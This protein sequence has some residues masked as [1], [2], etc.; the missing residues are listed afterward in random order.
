MQTKSNV[1]C[2]YLKGS[3]NGAICD[4]TNNFIRE[5]DDAEIR[6]CMNRRYEVCSIYVRLLQKE[7]LRFVNPDPAIK[8]L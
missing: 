3:I 1:V 7:A 4:V 8:R 2:P 5:M 6:L